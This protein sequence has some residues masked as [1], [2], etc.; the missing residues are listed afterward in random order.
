MSVVS[1][2][3]SWPSL[4]PQKRRRKARGGN[5][6]KEQK[7]FSLF[8]LGE[9]SVAWCLAQPLRLH[10]QKPLTDIISDSN[11]HLNKKGQQGKAGKE[12]QGKHQRGGNICRGSFIDEEGEKEQLRQSEMVSEFQSPQGAVYRDGVVRDESEFEI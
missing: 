5:E 2:R 7:E 10:L 12:C 6:L 1:G 11:R 4:L 9:S 8:Q 3:S